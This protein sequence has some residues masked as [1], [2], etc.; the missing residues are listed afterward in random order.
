MLQG[1]VP[2]LGRLPVDEQPETVLERQLGVGRTLA[3]LGE[4]AGHAREVE[5]EQ[6]V[7]GGAG[8]HVV[9]SMTDAVTVEAGHL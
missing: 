7:E 4:G 6:L 5:R 1:P 3:L 2:A 8:E 9:S